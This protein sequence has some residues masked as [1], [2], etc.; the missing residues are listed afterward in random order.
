MARTIKARDLTARQTFIDPLREGR[1]EATVI[2]VNGIT[3]GQVHLT[4]DD[5]APWGYWTASYPQD[6]DLELA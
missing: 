1:R 2:E 3:G 6:Q 5:A 4:L